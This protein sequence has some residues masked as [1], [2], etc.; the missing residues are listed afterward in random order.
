MSDHICRQAAIEYVKAQRG[1]MFSG[2]TIEEGLTML[3]N[4]VPSAPV[5]HWIPCSE[6]LPAYGEKCLVTFK[7][8]SH[9]DTHIGVSYCYVQK[10]GFWSDTPFEY[11]A[12]AWMPLPEPYKEG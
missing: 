7:L 2:V 11:K 10:E 6:R 3:I 4:E 1:R 9:N 12:V 8:N 5:P